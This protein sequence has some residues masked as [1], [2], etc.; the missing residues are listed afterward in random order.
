MSFCQ[1]CGTQI[2]GDALL[3]EPCSVTGNPPQQLHGRSPVASVRPRTSLLRIFLM[4]AICVVIVLFSLGWGYWKGMSA[5]F[6]KGFKDGMLKV[7]EADE[8]QKGPNA[9]EVVL[10]EDMLLNSSVSTAMDVL[11]G[12]TSGEIDTIAALMDNH[13]DQAK[14]IDLSDCPADFTEA[15]SKYVS[16]LADEAGA[17]RG[18]PAVVSEQEA[19]LKEPVRC[20]F[21]TKCMDEAGDEQVQVWKNKVK[22]SRDELAKAQEDLRHIAAK[23]NVTV[24]W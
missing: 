7:K 16:A 18:H 24:R 9:V 12:N 8:Q 5:G 2:S 6:D 10:R 19:K 17:V 20:F 15:Y 1:K 13:V 3:C 14:K 4:A 21:V 22:M 11:K 23:Y